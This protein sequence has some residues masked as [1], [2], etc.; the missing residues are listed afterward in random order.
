VSLHSPNLTNFKGGIFMSKKITFLVLALIVVFSFS[1]T[2]EYKMAGPLHPV[3]LNTGNSKAILDAVFV[4]NSVNYRSFNPGINNHVGT[5]PGG[6][7]AV[8]T[9]RGPSDTE[10]SGSYFYY[11]TDYGLNWTQ[12]PA[13]GPVLDPETNYERMYTDMSLGSS[14]LLY[15]PYT[16]NNI[17]IPG[18]GADGD[19]IV[20]AADL[21]GL[22]AG[23]WI[24]LPIADNS[25]GNYRYNP[26]ITLI[27]DDTIFVPIDDIGSDQIWLNVSV[28]YG[29]TW[30]ETG[31]FTAADFTALV[32]ATPEIDNV[33]GLGVAKIQYCPLSNE[34]L[35]IC[36]VFADAYITFPGGDSLVLARGGI[37]AYY[38]STD[39]GATWGDPQW[40]FPG[41]LP[42]GYGD[43]EDWWYWAMWDCER[44]SDGKIIIVSEHLTPGQLSGATFGSVYNGAWTTT[45]INT[46]EPP[47]ITYG[48][49]NKWNIQDAHLATDDAGY[50]FIVWT[51]ITDT[52][53]SAG[54]DTVYQHIRLA[55][56]VYNGTSWSTASVVDPTELPGWLYLSL[57]PK[58]D[59]QG[60]YNIGM[61]L[62]D[63]DSL[64]FYRDPPTGI[65][66]KKHSSVT[67]LNITTPGLVSNSTTIRFSV[68]NG[69]YGKLD[70]FDM[71]G[72]LVKTLVNG[73]VNAGN[74]SVVWNRTDNRNEKVSGGVYF[75]KLTVGNETV[76]RKIIAVK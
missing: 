50:A 54:G 22:G 44:T 63:D 67:L 29:F 76:T 25:D 28:D 40:V 70:V 49:W 57:A 16:A 30:N 14:D 33:Y 43:N 48:I 10:Y 11:S 39:M 53:M 19:T 34:L 3:N 74:H 6:Q 13:T 27:S 69:G 75:Y 38:V 4:C 59:D 56:S 17:R 55:N 5:T 62:T 47:D 71:T 24:S 21:S 1:L 26:S 7:V 9:N 66:E 68:S 15:S 65:A 64:W 31:P 8:Y 18:G 51:D 46:P 32:A 73:N 20:F 41:G 45:K 37:M 2:A 60:N 61:T 35:L 23:D 36:D 72:K 12:S 58:L 42:A 52:T